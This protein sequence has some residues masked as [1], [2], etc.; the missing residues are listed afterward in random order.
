MKRYIYQITNDVDNM[1]YI[2]STK[3]MLDRWKKHRTNFRSEARDSHYKLYEHLRGIGIDH[4][5]IEKIDEIMCKTRE[6][7]RKLEQHYIDKIPEQFRLNDRNAYTDRQAYIE[8]R[9]S[10]KKLYDKQYRG[11]NAELLKAKRKEYCKRNREK[12]NEYH[13]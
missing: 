3:D 5:K 13:L 2:G 7:A 11:K 12:I 9:I 8:S 6:D 10:K 1:T 4:C